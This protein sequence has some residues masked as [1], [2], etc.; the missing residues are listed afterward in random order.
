MKIAITTEEG[1]IFQHF[2]QC[3][4][5][6]IYTIEDGKILN[7]VMLD[8]SQSGHSAMTG[9]LNSTDVNVVICGGIGG[10]AKKMLESAG[11]TLISGIE[12]SI[13]TAINAYLSGQLTDAG[14]SCN[15]HDHDESHE[16]SC[17]NHCS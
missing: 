4:L 14:S 9:L 8:S 6:T 16:C 11:I 7:K 1:Q 12:G 5:Y 13:E 17:A 3:Q 15:H 2:G 10:G